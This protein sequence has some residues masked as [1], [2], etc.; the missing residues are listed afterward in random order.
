MKNGEKDI[1]VNDNMDLNAVF[2]DDFFPCIEGHA[3]LIDD[4]LSPRNSLYYST[5]KY[6]E[7]KLYDEDHD[8]PDHIV[9]MVYT[10]MIEVVSEVEQ[11]V[12]NL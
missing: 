8:D 12:R 2:L 7:M 3:K 5:V 1:E 6:D 4:Y 11:G 10:I 9:K